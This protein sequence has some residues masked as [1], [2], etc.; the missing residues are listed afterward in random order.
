MCPINL[1]IT[2]LLV[3][4][5]PRTGKSYFT[6]SLTWVCSTAMFCIHRQSHIK[7]W[8]SCVHCWFLGW[9]WRTSSTS[10]GSR[11][12]WGSSHYYSPSRATF[13]VLWRLRQKRKKS[14]EVGTGVQAVPL[15]FTGS[16][17]ICC[18]HFWRPLRPGRKRKVSS[19]SSS[20]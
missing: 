3:G 10:G 14:V 2:H 1:F 5:P 20:V 12:W 18:K 4:Q 17:P 15:G 16:F 13:T 11:R 9:R 7:K 8:F 6:I 19:R